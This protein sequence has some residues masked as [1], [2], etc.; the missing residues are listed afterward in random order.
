[1]NIFIFLTLLNV[2]YGNNVPFQMY[3]ILGEYFCSYF[4]GEEKYMVLADIDLIND[5][6]MVSNIYYRVPLDSFEHINTVFYKEKEYKV[7]QLND[8]ITL[9][10]KNVENSIPKFNF[11]FVNKEIS[12]PNSLSLSFKYKDNSFSIVHL[13]FESNLITKKGFYFGGG[14]L[15]FGNPPTDSKITSMHQATCKVNNNKE[16]FDKSSWGCDINGIYL[17]NSTIKPYYNNVYAKFTGINNYIIIPESFMKYLNDT[18]FNDLKEFCKYQLLSWTYSYRCHSSVLKEMQNNLVVVIDG[19][20]FEI[21]KYD[22]FEFDGFYVNLLFR[23]RN[24]INNKCNEWDIGT[25]FLSK[26]NEYFDYDNK[27]VTFYS[28]NPFIILEL[29]GNSEYKDVKICFYLFNI[30]ILIINII[31]IAIYQKMWLIK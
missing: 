23:V 22:M 13:L 1:M 29:K 28:N 8:I 24:E 3:Q 10:K 30:N 20:G 25:A 27:S 7:S 18:L 17:T 14:D 19:V 4:L 15:I 6:S 26:Y 12:G 2:C 16:Y 21:D 31:I 11:Y 5:F 9:T